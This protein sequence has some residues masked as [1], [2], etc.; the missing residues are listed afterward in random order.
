MVSCHR[1]LHPGLRLE[2]KYA[3][4]WNNLGHSYRKTQQYIMA[5]DAYKQA[6]NLAP[7]Y[8]NPHEYLA[9]TYLA[10][11]NKDAAMREYEIVWRPR[12]EDG[13]RTAEGNPKPTISIWETRLRTRG[14]AAR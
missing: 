11:G 4:A 1:R 12:C 2:P 3:A 6:M 13:R 5:L 7:D 10:T 14:G 9:R 8:S